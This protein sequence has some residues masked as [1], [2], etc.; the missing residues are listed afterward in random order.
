M[1]M[2]MEKIHTAESSLAPASEPHFSASFFACVSRPGN[3]DF[4]F[5]DARERSP[6][7]LRVSYRL[8]RGGCVVW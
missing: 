2:M 3:S 4:T 7:A 8:V 5:A 1:M 6:V